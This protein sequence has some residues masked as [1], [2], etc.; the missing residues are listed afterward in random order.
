MTP[1]NK[2]RLGSSNLRTGQIQQLRTFINKIPS[3]QQLSSSEHDTDSMS[4]FKHMI[5]NLEIA[6][7][8]NSLMTSAAMTIQT[9]QELATK[10]DVQAEN[11]F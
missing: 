2:K 6:S 3:S 7:N 11:V 5:S 8:N 4:D 10:V 1:D 9:N